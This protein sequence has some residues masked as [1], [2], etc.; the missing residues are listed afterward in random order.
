MNRKKLIKFSEYIQ[1][2]VERFAYLGSVQPKNSEF[3]E[4]IKHIINCWYMKQR[5]VS[6]ISCDM[7]IQLD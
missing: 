7:R 3:E 6:D 5:K 1:G 4:N 2:E